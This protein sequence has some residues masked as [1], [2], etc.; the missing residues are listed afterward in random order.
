LQY[1]FALLGSALLVLWEFS[2]KKGDNQK[3]RREASLEDII[4]GARS[5]DA[6][7]DE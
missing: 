3:R 5:I 1:I 7:I 4:Q 2:T 6:M